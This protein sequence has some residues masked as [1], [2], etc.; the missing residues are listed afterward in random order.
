MIPFT[1]VSACRQL[2]K[3]IRAEMDAEGKGH[4]S[5]P[6]MEITEHLRSLSGRDQTRIKSELGREMD[7]ALAVRGL[8]AFPKIADTTAGDWVRIYRLGKTV[9]SLIDLIHKP[10][11]EGDAQLAGMVTKI[12]APPVDKAA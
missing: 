5:M 4:K 11:L 6:R 7:E 12:K 2:A 10:S 8:G 3:D 9:S 1:L